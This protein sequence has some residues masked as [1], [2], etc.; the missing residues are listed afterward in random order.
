MKRGAVGFQEITAAPQTIELSP[1]MAIGMAVGANILE[2]NPAVIRTGVT[3]AEV[4]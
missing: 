4:V 1:A 3:R 2:V